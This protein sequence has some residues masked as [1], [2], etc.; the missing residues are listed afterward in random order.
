MSLELILIILKGFLIITYLV[1]I[2]QISCRYL[3]F[4]QQEEYDSP[5]FLQWWASNKAFEK[6]RNAICI[7]YRFNYFPLSARKWESLVFGV[8]HYFWSIGLGGC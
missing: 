1:M 8:K 6:T 7:L 4:Y 5:R 3:Q 2:W